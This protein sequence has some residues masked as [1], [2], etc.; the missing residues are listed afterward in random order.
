MEKLLENE[1]F[2][3]IF[4][5]NSDKGHVYAY[6]DEIKISRAFYNMLINAVNYSGDNR[7]ITVTQA[8]T[9]VAT[10][11]GVATTA[12]TTTATGVTTATGAMVRI[13]VTD[14]G[15]GISEDEL[16]FIWDRYYKSGKKHKRPVTGTGLGLPIVKKVIELHGGNYG[17]TSEMGKGST[18]WFEINISPKKQN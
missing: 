18:F 12:G 10:A 4:K 1:G 15:E 16:S 8:T 6:A 14:S 11:T 17:V 13:S 7:V 9:G 2:T 5:N 3:I